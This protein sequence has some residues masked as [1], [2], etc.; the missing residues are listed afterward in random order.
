MPGPV[1]RR[2]E[3]VTLR[4]VEDEDAEFLAELVNDPRVR[5]G[6]AMAD[7]NSVD[8]ERAWIDSTGD[9]SEVHLLA[10]VDAEPVGIVGLNRPNETFGSVELGYQFAPSSWGNGYATDAAR[11]TCGHAFDTRRFHKVYAD[12]FE[13]NPASAR[14]LE[15]VGFT[16]EGRHREQAFVDG[17]R[18]DVL[19]YGLLADEWFGADGE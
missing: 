17:E 6:T 5:A 15:K 14:V 9:T 19:R 2:G 12:V 11:E 1:F 3:T 13:T 10:C 7:P 4:P 16:E 8:D 18:V